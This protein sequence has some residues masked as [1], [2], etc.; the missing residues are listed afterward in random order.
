MR[1]PPFLPVFR[2]A[3]PNPRGLPGPTTRV[4]SREISF[5]FP[6]KD[7]PSPSNGPPKYGLLN[8]QG[9]FKK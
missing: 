4:F 8:P 5:G 3:P 2:G 6:A 9:N 1:A 7:P